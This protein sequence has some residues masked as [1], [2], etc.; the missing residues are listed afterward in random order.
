MKFGMLLGGGRD[1]GCWLG[2]LAA[3]RHTQSR[4]RPPSKVHMN[5]V[6][7]DRNFVRFFRI[8]II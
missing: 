1:G 7:T 2:G 3:R 6:E 5:G 4:I 8:H